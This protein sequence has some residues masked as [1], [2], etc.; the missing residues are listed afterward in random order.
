MKRKI[1]SIDKDKCNGC[2][3]CITACHEGALELIDGKATL[4][5]DIYC[6]G[7]GDCLPGCPMDAINI[8][9]RDAE[10]Y[11]DDAVQER[12]RKKNLT[13]STDI[14]DFTPFGCPSTKV[15]MNKKG[16]SKK[17]EVQDNEEIETAL[18]QWPCQ[19]KLVSP[20]APFFRDAE[21]LIAADCTAF[22][23]RDMHNIMEGKIT[24]IGCPKLDSVD[25]SEKL[26]A[27]LENNRIKSIKVVRM[28]VPCCGGLV[29]AV[30]R[31][32]LKSEKVVPWETITIGTDGRII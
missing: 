16:N 17:V 7:F 23:Y 10:E 31:A 6:D 9:E 28:E 13:K 25:Y 11:D 29:E 22:A 3:I 5:S 21:L 14:F 15:E 27:I 19:I 4:V 18:A 26:S 2:G 8:I 12:I 30:K 24:L 1:V 32:M 20:N